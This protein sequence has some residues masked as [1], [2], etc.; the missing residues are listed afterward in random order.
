MLEGQPYVRQWLAGHDFAT[1]DQ[2]AA[3]MANFAYAIGDRAA[4][5]ALLVDPAYAPGELVDLL[6]A[7]GMTVAGVL[8]THHHPDHVGGRLGSWQ[9]DG[10]AALLE[11][12][13]VPVHAAAP[14]VD[15][16]EAWSGIPASSLVGHHGGDRIAVGDV[17]VELVHTPGHTPGSCCLLVGGALVS[18]DTLF[19]DGCGRTDLPGGDPGQLYDSL[20]G[21]AALPA[22]TVVLPGHRYSP[23]P[24]LPL[25]DV[26]QRNV[27]LRPLSREQWLGMF[28]PHALG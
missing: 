9:I 20:R 19:L 15:L 24:M 13:D 10:L 8:V 11:E 23:E 7:D 2:V 27:A 3:N 25:G 16:V 26:T 17:E 18:G 22:S 1:G 6:A 12:V 5:R 4:G 14:E 21:L 28:A